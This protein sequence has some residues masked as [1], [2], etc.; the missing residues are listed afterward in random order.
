MTED[1][2]T[3]MFREFQSKAALETAHTHAVAYLD[4]V[5]DRR[6]YPGAQDLADLARV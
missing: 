6:V 4:G 3:R 2:Q 1:F 5:R